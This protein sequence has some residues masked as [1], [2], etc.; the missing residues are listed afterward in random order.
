M[1]AGYYLHLP[2]QQRTATRLGGREGRAQGVRHVLDHRADLAGE[3]VST[4]SLSYLV[5]A[6]THAIEAGHRH[7]EGRQLVQVQVDYQVGGQVLPGK[8]GEDKQ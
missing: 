8:G 5:L 1:L 4:R 7:G 3:R 2:G 6:G